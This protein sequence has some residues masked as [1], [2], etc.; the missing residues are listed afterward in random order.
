MFDTNIFNAILDGSVE[1]DKFRTRYMLY[2]TH[3]QEDEL[4]ATITIDRRKK[5][6]EVFKKAL[7]SDTSGADESVLPT[8]TMVWDVS[9]W[10][11]SKWGANGGQY[12]LIKDKLDKRNKNKPNNVRDALIA[13]TAIINQLILVIHDGDLFSVISEIGGYA[14]NLPMLLGE[15]L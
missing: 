13:E 11:N 6:L 10:G 9:R 4:S 15:K 8:E 1:L 2:V 7:S 14:T 12:Q 3:V 5:L